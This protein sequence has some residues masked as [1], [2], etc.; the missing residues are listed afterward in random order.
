MPTL[1]SDRNQNSTILIRRGWLSAVEEVTAQIVDGAAARGEAHTIACA[2]G[3]LFAIIGTERDA[4]RGS[5]TEWLL[6]S[7]HGDSNGLATP[8]VVAAIDAFAAAR[9]PTHRLVIGLDANAWNSSKAGVMSYDAFLLAL[10]AASLVTHLHKEVTGAGAAAG[11][12]AGGTTG[13][14]ARTA[15]AAMPPA[16]ESAISSNIARTHLQPQFH[17]AIFHADVRT[18]SSAKPCDYVLFRAAQFASL[19][20]LDP[21][22]P[23]SAAAAGSGAQ[24]GGHRDNTGCGAFRE[25]QLCPTLTYPSDHCIVSACLVP[26]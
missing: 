25:G 11:T 23:A 9:C 16:V 10:D 21:V 4:K 14:G 6:V 12:T 1:A 8:R 7:F 5:E 20:A 2:D 17:K 18:H 3:D 22:V 26:K 13:P 15:S 19:S 24:C